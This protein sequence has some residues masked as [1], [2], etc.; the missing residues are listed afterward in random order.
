MGQAQ[1]LEFKGIG[2]SPGVVS[3][4]VRLLL[5]GDDPV[6]DYALRPGDVPREMMRLETALI[7]TRQQLAEIQRRVSQ[8]LGGESASIFEAHL[9]VVDD[10]DFL[11]E[12]YREVRDKL[13]NIEKVFFDVAERYAQTLLQMEDDYLRERATDIRDVTRRI[14]RNLMGGGRDWLAGLEE[15]QIIVAHDIPP[16]EMAALDRGKILGLAMEL[17]SVTSHAAI[18][19]R[20]MELPTVVGLRDVY[21]KLADGDHVVLDGV[22]GMLVVNPTPAT[23]R[24][25]TRIARGR[26]E[27]QKR[28]DTFKDEPAVTLDGVEIDLAANI[29][30]PA[31]VT[32]VLARGARGIG[33][34]RSEYLYLANAG[35]PT[36]DQHYAA[37]AQVAKAMLPDP[38]IIRTLDLGGDKMPAGDRRTEEANP[39]MGWRAIRLSLARQEMFKAQL[40][41]I[42]RASAHNP[43]LRI[44]YPM[45]S[46]LAEV[47]QAD[48]LLREC[49]DE[50]AA[51]GVDFNRDIEIGVMIE[52]PSAALIADWIAPKVR[53]FSIGTNDLVQYTLAVDRVNERVAHLYEPT[54][55][56]VLHLI[57]HTVEAGNRHGVWTG[58]CGEM[59]A[60]P[61]FVPLLLGLGVV[62]LSVSPLAVPVVKDV[63]RRIEM[64]DAQALA[65]EARKRANGAEVLAL[66]RQLLRRRAPDLLELAE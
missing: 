64:S 39:F 66:C 1:E 13:R 55:P 11:M 6:P 4:R 54:H 57:A 47:E 23:E 42:L 43:K 65:A 21:E 41:A 9:Q 32:A 2:V 38:V 31:D 33:L 61:Y 50:L 60:T 12:V 59:A 14:L 45:I 35:D 25:Y 48:A 24:E 15:P 53:F 49:M 26:M 17:G 29:E 34:F 36:E 10:R 40:R 19:A 46:H 30:M 37:Y 3:G 16:S 22:R 8:A 7:E 18:M 62:S 51:A 20:A 58:V 5:S 28:L 56:A 44:M 27:I 52:V 63:I